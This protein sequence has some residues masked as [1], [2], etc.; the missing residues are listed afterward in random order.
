M[1]NISNYR[2][3]STS[4]GIFPFTQPPALPSPP[5]TA[6][7]Y[8]N[9]HH[10][11]FL[12]HRYSTPSSQPPGISAETPSRITGWA[13]FIWLRDAS[14]TEGHSHRKSA[15]ARNQNISRQFMVPK[16]FFQLHTMGDNHNDRGYHCQLFDY[17]QYYFIHH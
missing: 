7:Y 14:W 8:Y 12:S 17:L 9:L 13:A 3:I 1:Q 5:T 16:P 2:Q 4:F 6:Y 10:L 11:S 15:Q